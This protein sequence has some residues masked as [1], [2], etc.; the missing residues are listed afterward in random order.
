MESLAI[1]VDGYKFLL[2]LQIY[3]RSYS[4][5]KSILTQVL[6][7]VLVTP[8]VP[9]LALRK[10]NGNDTT[11]IRCAFT[12]QFLFI[13]LENL[14][15]FCYVLTTAMEEN[16]LLNVKYQLNYANLKQNFGEVSLCFYVAI[17]MCLR[18][19]LRFHSYSDQPMEIY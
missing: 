17:N 9:I 1:I 18:F 2:L 13:D 12:F 4:M 15:N 11:K 8:L 14:N 16:I 7:G 3:L 6:I 19:F 5:I 10:R